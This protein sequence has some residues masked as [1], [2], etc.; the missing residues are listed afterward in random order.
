MRFEHPSLRQGLVGCWVPSLGASGLSLIDRSGRNNHGTLTNMGGQNN[1]RASGSG[2]AL[3]FD[4]TNDFV[5]VGNPSY[6]SF[7]SGEFALSCWVRPASLHTG[8]SSVIIGKDVSAGRQFTLQVNVDNTAGTAGQL[9]IVVLMSNTTFHAQKTNANHLAASEWT[10]VAAGR[11]GTS[12]VIF[13]NGVEV[14]TSQLS[15]STALGAMQTTSTAMR[16]GSREFAGA[17]GFFS[18]LMDDVRVYNRFPTAAEI[19][20]LASRRGIGLT[21]LPDRA[22]SLPR[23]LF[24]NVGGTWRDGDAYVNV[25]GTWKLGTPFVNAGGTWK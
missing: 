15:G 1:W 22:V 9:C 20:L 10:H 24:V 4:G 17:E 11:R 7:G 21:P 12:L 3:N 6:L 25:G 8:I 16:I 5:T 13:A 18:G 23:K 2:V 14:A 19:R